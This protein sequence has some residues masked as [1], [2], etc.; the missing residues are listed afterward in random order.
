MSFSRCQSPTN[1]FGARMPDIQGVHDA[2]ALYA[3]PVIL[4]TMK[5]HCRP[6]SLLL[7]EDL[8]ICGF[9]LQLARHVQPGLL[10]LLDLLQVIDLVLVQLHDLCNCWVGY[11]GSRVADRIL[12]GNRWGS[13]SGRE[14]SVSR[15]LMMMMV[16]MVVRMW[17]RLRVGTLGG[18]SR[19]RALVPDGRG[20]G[21]GLG[22]AVMIT[23]L[24][25][26]KMEGLL[27]T[28]ANLDP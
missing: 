27:V 11:A 7:S 2:L 13:I 3:I 6:V 1:A 9:A 21:W 8:A 10:L 26:D 20:P 28:S 22:A 25:H 16:V 14:R 12:I 19:S 5:P 15:M 4:N 17:L 24:S 23:E 18:G